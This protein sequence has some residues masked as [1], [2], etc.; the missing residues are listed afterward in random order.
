MSDDE[1][2][3]IRRTGDEEIQLNHE[4]ALRLCDESAEEV[5]IVAKLLGEVMTSTT[6]SMTGHGEDE[7]SVTLRVFMLAEDMD[8]EL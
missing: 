6:D 7:R 3:V 2:P 8:P 4:A 1:A 5:A